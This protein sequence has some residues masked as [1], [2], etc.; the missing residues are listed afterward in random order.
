MK[1]TNS[2]AIQEY[3]IEESKLMK[4]FENELKGIYWG[5]KALTN[6]LPKMTKR[7]VG[8][9]NECLANAFKRNRNTC[10]KNRK[11]I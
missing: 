3:G 6:A 9:T 11:S 8:K 2:G 4:L 5:E 10:S 7:Y 1:I